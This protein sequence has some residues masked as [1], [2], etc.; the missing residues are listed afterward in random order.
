MTPKQIAQEWLAAFNR[1]DADSMVALYAD[2]AVHT[3]PRIRAQ[4]ASGDGQIVG[5]AAMHHWWSSAFEKQD[6]LRYEVITLVADERCAVIEYRRH[7]QG[8]PTSRV[9]ELFEILEGKII[10]SNVYLGN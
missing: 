1:G 3:S 5:K 8:E 7:A 2:D 10:R 9:A 4:G 6:G